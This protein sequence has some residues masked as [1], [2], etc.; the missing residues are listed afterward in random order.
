M[1]KRPS[2]L[3]RRKAPSLKKMT[4]WAKT[5]KAQKWAGFKSL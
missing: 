5:K 3:G 4:A 2:I 1:K